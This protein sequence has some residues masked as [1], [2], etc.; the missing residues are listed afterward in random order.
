MKFWT[1]LAAQLVL[2]WALIFGIYELIERRYL[3]DADPTLIH[4]LHILRGSSTA[5]LLAWLG[6]RAVYRRREAFI[7]ESKER[8]GTEKSRQDQILAEL[9]AGLVVLDADFRVVFA[10]A[11]AQKWL[12][13]KLSS[14]MCLS[15][16]CAMGKSTGIC[17]ARESL[18]KT[19]RVAYE[20]KV[21]TPE[22]VRHLYITATP[23]PGSNG[24]GS[25]GVIELIQ[26]I[27]PLK[28]MEARLRQSLAAA[29]VGAVASGVA[30]Q[31]GNPLATV[32]AAVERLYSLGAAK[33][34]TYARY[35]RQIEVES[36]RAVKIIRSLMDLARRIGGKKE[37]VAETA[38]PAGHGRPSVER[39]RDVK[40]STTDICVSI[41]E[42][43]DAVVDA[44]QLSRECIKLFLPENPLPAQINSVDTREILI[45]LL[46]NA[47]DATARVPQP[48]IAVHAAEEHGRILVMVCDNGPGI[49][50]SAREK[51]FE[52]FYTTRRDGLGLGLFL[53]RELV[54][55][56]GGEVW[57]DNLPTGGARFL[58][59]LPMAVE[60]A[61]R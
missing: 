57:A 40:R 17:P 25:N 2:V 24:N 9:G 41:T 20:E 5:F 4:V 1:R 55:S 54:E 53:C 35:L 7:V 50:Q 3:Q 49:D 12:G 30:H 18:I 14:R 37:G 32:S 23:M 59:R 22:G 28:E 44:R 33:H 43:V 10:N 6:V 36:D 47:L 29:R 60:S 31:I 21:E 8:L 46:N 19:H 56:A 61:V 48:P 51:M 16:D 26:D 27:T 45:N 42:A 52:P 15:E 13:T 58:I 34:E 38:I 39:D 11:Q